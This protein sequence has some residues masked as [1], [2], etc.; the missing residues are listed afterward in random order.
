M[1]EDTFSHE[2]RLN[3]QLHCAAQRTEEEFIQQAI[4]LGADVTLSAEGYSRLG[5]TEFVFV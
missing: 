4:A 1:L 2:V 5:R 3:Q